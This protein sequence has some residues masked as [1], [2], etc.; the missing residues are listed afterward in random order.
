M[1]LFEYEGKSILKKHGL[2]IMESFVVETTTAARMAAEKI[3]SKIILKAQIS[4]GKRGKRGLIKFADTPE[5]AEKDAREIFNRTDIP[6]GP[7]THI[8]VEPAVNIEKEY[9]LAVIIDRSSK[10]IMIMFSPQ[11]GVDIEEVASQTPE[12]IEKMYLHFSDIPYPF[13]FFPM[14]SQFGIE[15]KRKLLLADILTKIVNCARTEDLILTEI[16]PFIFTPTGDPVVLDAKIQVD[17]GASFRH[18]EYRTFK[19]ISKD[20]STYEKEAKDADLAY[21]QL[22]GDIGMIS[23]GAGLSMATCDIIEKFGGKA[24]NFLDVGGGASPQKVEAALNI[25]FTQSHIRGIL[26]N[27]FGGITR[28]EEVAKGIIQALKKNPNHVPIIVRLIGTNDK[29]GVALLATEGIE[30]YIEME[31]AIKRIMEV[32]K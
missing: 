23:C 10:K 5:D 24:A 15:G 4:G 3:S 9:Y 12:A 26:I 1:V 6:E 7:I 31:P 8:L 13:R 32:I 29:E 11:G 20:L 16:N 28:G 2:P 14:L 19:S 22:D 18:P 30:A 21:V 25:L 27:V 17:E